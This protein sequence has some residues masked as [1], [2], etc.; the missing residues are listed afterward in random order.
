MIKFNKT[1]KNIAKLFVQGAEFNFEGVSY[2]V[3]KSG[4]PRP[5]KGECK[6]DVY[7]LAQTKTGEQKEF[8]ISVKQNN[9]DFLENKIEL[10]RAIEILGKDAQNIIKNSIYNI[11]HSFEKDCLIRFNKY[12]KTEA[13]SIKLGWRFE[14]VNVISGEKSGVLLL[15]DKQKIGIFSG[16]NLSINKRNCYLEKELIENS[17]VA[18]FILITDGEELSLQDCINHLIPIND[19]AKAQTIYFACKACNYRFFKKKCEGNRGLAV[20]VKWTIENKMLQ[21][22]II[23]EEPLLH[24][25][26][27]IR[28]N[29]VRLLINMDA[30]SD[31]K[32]LKLVLS[33]SVNTDI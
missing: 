16:S 32:K 23:Y 14:L 29:L 3:L 11:K 33:E 31:I 4:K 7:A 28:D 25:A 21:G 2:K 19:Y 6:T 13:G 30:D 12:G 15:S 8:K 26:Y 20:Y 10:G 27:E 17:G 22:N 9:A 1:E 5:N 18:D 24:K